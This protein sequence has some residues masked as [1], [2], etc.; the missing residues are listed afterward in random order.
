MFNR[1]FFSNFKNSGKRLTFKSGNTANC[2]FNTV[3]I[4]NGTK[5]TGLIYGINGSGESLHSR[6]DETLLHD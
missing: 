3:T 1:F 2:G 6:G 5:A 4:R